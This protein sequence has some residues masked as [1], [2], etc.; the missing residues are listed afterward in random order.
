MLTFKDKFNL[1]AENNKITRSD[2]VEKLRE[3]L[4]DNALNHLPVNGIRDIDHA[5]EYLDQAFGNPH[6]CLNH[7]LAK[8]TAMPGLTDNLERQDPAYAAEWYVKME[9]AVDAVLRMGSR[10]QSLE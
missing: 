5:W 6:T 4:T 8:V 9:N 3:V 10:N 1:A 7:R 2:Q